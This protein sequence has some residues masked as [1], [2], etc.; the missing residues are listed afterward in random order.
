VVQ[1]PKEL[2]ESLKAIESF[3][4]EAFE[5]IHASGEQIT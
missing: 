4:Q 2:L 3:D 5:K 1:L